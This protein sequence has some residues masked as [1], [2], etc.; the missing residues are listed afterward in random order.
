MVQ[1]ARQSTRLQDLQTKRATQA[2]QPLSH[3]LCENPIVTKHTATHIQIHNVMVYNNA[4]Q[5]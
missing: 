1:M 5:L 2:G 4:F 3:L